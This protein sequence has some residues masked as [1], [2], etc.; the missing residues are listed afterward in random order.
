MRGAELPARAIV[1]AEHD[2]AA[3]LAAGHVEHFGCVV[4]DRAAI[5]DR[6]LDRLD[7]IDH[8]TVWGDVHQV[9]FSHVLGDFPLVGTLLRMAGNRHRWA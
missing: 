8:T 7:R 2:R 3:Q 5:I 9:D 4:E 1:S 6:C